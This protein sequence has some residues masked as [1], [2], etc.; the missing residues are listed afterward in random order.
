MPSVQ[1]MLRAL[2][3]CKLAAVASI[4][5]LASVCAPVASSQGS[6]SVDYTPFLGHWSAHGRDISIRAVGATGEPALYAEGVASWRT[7]GTCRPG[8]L[9]PCDI[10]T[11]RSVIIDGGNALIAFMDVNGNRLTGR[12]LATSGPASIPVGAPATLV[13]ERYGMALLVMGSKESSN[14][15]FPWAQPG[16]VQADLASVH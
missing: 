9:G 16:A 2:A 1:T 14:N 11:D 13:L 15:N 8:E 6:N 12:V 10:F 7:Y 3:T 5:F 4:A